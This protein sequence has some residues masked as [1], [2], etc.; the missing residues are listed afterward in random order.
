[1]TTATPA[2]G[3]GL[4][5]GLSRI[6]WG[7]F[8]NLKAWRRWFSESLVQSGRLTGL[9]AIILLFFV[10]IDDP[11]W[12]QFLR[13]KVFD[14]YQQI[15]PRAFEP[16][17][18]VLIVD[19]DEKSIEQLGQ[20]PWPRTTIAQIIDKLAE[21][22]AKVIG[23]DVVFAESDRT[24]LRAIA[25]STTGI[26]A[27]TR[28]AMR[29]A[30][31]NDDVLAE[32]IQKS[33]RVVLGQTIPDAPIKYKEERPTTS[34]VVV[35][36][37]PNKFMEQYQSLQRNILLIDN[38][39]EGH[40]VFSLSGTFVD[41]I[42]RDVPMVLVAD[43]VRY[44]SLSLE[45]LRVSKGAKSIQIKSN[46]LTGISELLMRPRGTRDYFSVPTDEAGRK[47]VY[48]TPHAAFQKNYV[49][50]VDILNGTID[51]ARVADKMILIG[52]SAQG[53]RDVR[54]TPLD[55]VLPGVEVH[56]NILENVFFVR[57]QNNLDE[58][59]FRI[60]ESLAHLG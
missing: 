20:W 38:A 35:G 25:E 7:R 52:T 40:G 16:N 23:F 42:S 22:N 58:L 1:M 8:F 21:M 4:P 36:D 45:M 60:A 57:R 33:G 48:Y 14:T 13:A 28:E 50:A 29:Q 30:R 46:D 56:A 53:L 3:P 24:S 15:K 54:A 19:I 43:G 27:K 44:P 32:A 12:L 9:L 18:P 6:P 34:F 59:G 2:T 55:R 39:A 5:L 37:N 49:S 31:D 11:N 41:G 47:K 26:D 17:S 10:R 51:P